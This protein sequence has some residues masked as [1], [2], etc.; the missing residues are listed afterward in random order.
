MT[1][2]ASCGLIDLQARAALLARYTRGLILLQEPQSTAG[3]NTVEKSKITKEPWFSP[4]N[5]RFG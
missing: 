2:G 3:T 4:L 5:L 1:G